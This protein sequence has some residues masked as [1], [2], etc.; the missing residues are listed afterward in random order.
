MV[1]FSTILLLLIFSVQVYAGVFLDAETGAVF[2]GMNDVRIPGNY[3]SRVSLTGVLKTG[4][5]YFVRA[6][7][8][9]EFMERHAVTFLAAPLSIESRGRSSRPV[10]FYGGFY[11]PGLPLKSV[12]TFNSYRLSYRY[13][14][15]NTKDFRLG[16]GL[17]AKIRDAYI[18][19]ESLGARRTRSNLGFV[20]LVNLGM[21]WRFAPKL[22]LVIDVDALA[23]PQG[24][25]EDI[26]AALQF[27]PNENLALR[28][29]YR[30]LEGGA[31]NKS[32]Y[33]FSLFH[34]VVAGVTY[35]I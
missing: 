13:Y 2:S 21:E 32:V 10:F 14:F 7:A 34:Y 11:P 27:S 33:T 5:S 1:K 9:V 29:G 19:M 26:L 16:A 4:P 12:F 20:P 35:R 8:G 30:I 24:R 17:T 6:R 25:A 3:G 22:A 15:I 28:A 31:D 18:S 23:A